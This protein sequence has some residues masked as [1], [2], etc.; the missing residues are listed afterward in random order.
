MFNFKQATKVDNKENNT[1]MK[2]FAIVVTVVIFLLFPL[3][4]KCHATATIYFVTDMAAFL[5][6]SVFPIHPSMLSWCFQIY[7]LWRPFWKSA[8][9]KGEKHR[10]SLNGRPQL[11]EKDAFT[12]LVG[13]LW[14]LSKSNTTQMFN[15]LCPY[16][17]DMANKLANS[18]LCRLHI[19]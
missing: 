18:C 15:R 10:F 3:P 4:M 19:Q 9:F 17:I 14:T 2:P 7:T 11:R 6:S 12:N 13:L 1:H 8:I 16:K 5:Q